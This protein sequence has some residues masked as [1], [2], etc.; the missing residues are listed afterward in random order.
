MCGAAPKL[1]GRLRQ[2]H[3]P[4]HSGSAGS[5]RAPPRPLPCPVEV[6]QQAD[7]G[8]PDEGARAGAGGVRPWRA[9][10]SCAN[11]AQ[12]TRQHVV[13][14]RAFPRRRAVGGGRGGSNHPALSAFE[15]HSVNNNSHANGVLPWLQAANAPSLLW[16][17]LPGMCASDRPADESLPRT[18]KRCPQP[19]T[20]SPL[21]QEQLEAHCISLILMIINSLFAS[22]SGA[23][24][25]TSWGEQRLYEITEPCPWL[26]Y[27][28]SF[29]GQY[30]IILQARA[31]N[32]WMLTMAFRSTRRRPPSGV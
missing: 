24:S 8:R 32:R 28:D 7:G 6:L 30:N 1:A 9:R 31:P 22:S 15:V 23:H 11:P 29:N 10:P 25:T 4:A 21:A 27:D 20:A 17:R 12:R 2:R 14:A 19:T 5:S 13:G 16:R 3:S 18:G 26:A